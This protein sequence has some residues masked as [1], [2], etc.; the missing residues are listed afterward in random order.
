MKEQFIRQGGMH[1]LYDSD[2]VSRFLPA[3]FEREA[4]KA[5]G[6]VEHETA[7][8]RM[9]AIFFT[10]GGAA[11]VL[12]HY[13]RGGWPGRLIRDRYGY[14]GE[15]AV[16]SFR[17]WRLLAELQKLGLPAPAPCAARYQRRGLCY[18][19]DLITFRCHGTEPLSQVLMRERLPAERWRALGMILRRFHD[20]GVYH[21][22]LNAHNI[23]LGGHTEE[24]FVVD[25]DKARIIG[26]DARRLMHNLARLQHSLSR[27]RSQSVSFMY[28]PWNFS[29]LLTGYQ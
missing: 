16:R 27:L 2:A 11:F 18:T 3:W 4:L 14:L 17:E 1:I 9:P 24:I 8:G 15:A 10:I 20:A 21:A 28:E 5:D 26:A 25:F 12:K 7:S 22:D 6:A 19:A 23:L 13:R 29:E